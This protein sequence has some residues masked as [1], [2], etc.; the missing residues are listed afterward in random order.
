MDLLAFN[1]NTGEMLLLQ[2][3]GGYLLY[4]NTKTGTFRT[5]EVTGLPQWTEDDYPHFHVVDVNFDD[6]ME[7]QNSF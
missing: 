1:Y 6:E 3:G 5:A 7:R 4:Y 2:G